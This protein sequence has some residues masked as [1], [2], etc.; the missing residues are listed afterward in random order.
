MKYTIKGQENKEIEFSLE[1]CKDGNLILKG[2]EY[3]IMSVTPD[4][5]LW[6]FSGIALEGIQINEIGQI[7]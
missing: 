1:I 5:R 2:N 3:R 6:K 4:G 7:L